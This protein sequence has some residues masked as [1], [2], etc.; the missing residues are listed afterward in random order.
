MVDEDQIRRNPEHSKT[1]R[2]QTPTH[3][4]LWR[5]VLVGIVSTIIGTTL[6]RSFEGFTALLTSRTLEAGIAVFAYTF[7]VLVIMLMIQ[8]NTG[9]NGKDA[10]LARN[11]LLH[12]E[13]MRQ[14]YGVPMS[15][16]RMSRRGY[17]L[18]NHIEP[19]GYDR[20]LAARDDMD[21]LHGHADEA[22]LWEA[23][24]RGESLNAECWRCGEPRFRGEG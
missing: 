21:R 16:E 23:I 7:V 15:W 5:P 2:F 22:G 18:A 19:T 8:I 10:A 9:R 12:E 6:I 24:Q 4:D 14:K 20:L 13:R 3:K 1:P 11:L 17:N